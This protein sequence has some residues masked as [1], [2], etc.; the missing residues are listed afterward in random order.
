MAVG[1]RR[2]RMLDIRGLI[3]Q[4]LVVMVV[5]IVYLALFVGASRSSRYS[6]SRIRRSAYW[7]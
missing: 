7:R 4:V 1:V 6:G 5:V 2:P 3:V